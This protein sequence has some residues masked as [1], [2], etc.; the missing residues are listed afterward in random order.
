MKINENE[1]IEF[2]NEKT[3]KYWKDFEQIL[4]EYN[5][6]YEINPDDKTGNLSQCLVSLSS[7]GNLDSK[8]MCDFLIRTIDSEIDF[9]DII[10]YM[11]I[12]EDIDKIVKMMSRVRENLFTICGDYIPVEIDIP[13]YCPRGEQSFSLRCIDINGI[14]QSINSFNGFNGS[15]TDKVYGGRQ[16]F[17]EGN[18]VFSGTDFTFLKA[19]VKL[20]FDEKYWLS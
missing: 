3:M 10:A 18:F 15:F 12:E 17:L 8:D 7:T 6:L 11:D 4:R 9:D 19:K 16:D 14:E 5:K 1:E 2:S 13:A 20:V